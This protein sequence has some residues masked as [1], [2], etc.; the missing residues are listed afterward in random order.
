[1]SYT[2]FQ[3]QFKMTWKQASWTGSW[4]KNCKQMVMLHS[5][6]SSCPLRH[7][8]EQCSVKSYLR[9]CSALE[10]DKMKWHLLSQQI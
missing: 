4:L 3:K 9:H 7:Q 8:K 6:V 5:N 2:I 10:S 1:M